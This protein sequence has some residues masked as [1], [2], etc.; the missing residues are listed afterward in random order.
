MEEAPLLLLFL[1]YKLR[2]FPVASLV[3]SQ[4]ENGPSL[5]DCYIRG[6]TRDSEAAREEASVLRV[7][8]F[9]S[10]SPET[11]GGAAQLRSHLEYLSGLEITWYYLAKGPAASHQ[12]GAK[13]LGENFTPSELLRDLSA[14]AGFLPGSKDRACRLAEQ[15]EADL[16]WVVG[17][18]EGLSV[19]AELRAQGKPVHL[20]I[21]DDPFGT[22]IRS[23][24]YRA[25]RPL[26]SC[27]YAKLLHAVNSIDVTSWSMR[28][29]YRQKY[30]VKCFSVYLHVPKLPQ[31]DVAP[32]DQSRITVGHIGTLYQAEPFRRFIASC[33]HIASD[34]KRALRI[35][36]IGSSPEIDMCTADDPTLYEA[37]GDLS[38]QA[39]VPLLASCDFLYA[40]YPPGKKYELFR[41][42]SLPI[43]LS[44]YVQAQRPIFAHA[45]PDST[46]ARAVGP[47]G[48]GRVCESQDQAE[49]G[50]QIKEVLKMP[51]SRDRFELLRSEL[52]GFDQVQQLGAALRGQ[53]GSGFVEYDFRS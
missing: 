48:V 10:F 46:L 39:A 33:R 40:M 52:M 5:S 37:H 53:D 26:L 16:Y 25:F 7:A 38:E 41:R 2:A 44:T 23:E 32:R 4:G 21:H 24:R 45:P 36:R 19:A 18:Y 34:E 35:V 1:L 9:T 51:V 12:V 43:K 17:H 20:T 42:T 8:L 15:M 47:Y 28:N 11:G 13:W 49:I 50:K 27:I 29:R 14:R 31:L 30:G 3:C 6:G 22:W